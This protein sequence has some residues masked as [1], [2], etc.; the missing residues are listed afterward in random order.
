MP[1]HDVIHTCQVGTRYLFVR[2]RCGETVD[3]PG[4]PK[5][6]ATI[7]TGDACP[8][9]V[10]SLSMIKEDSLLRLRSLAVKEES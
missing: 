1:L 4:V 10:A 8:E 7:G 3:I 2:A 6:P 9:C 5:R